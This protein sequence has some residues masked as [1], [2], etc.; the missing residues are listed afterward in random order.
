MSFFSGQADAEIASEVG[1][2]TVSETRYVAEYMMKFLRT[3]AGMAV[4][5]LAISLYCHSK[6]RCIFDIPPDNVPV[7][8]SASAD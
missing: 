8:A 6:G 5:W 7:G 3:R 2:V 4:G 1:H